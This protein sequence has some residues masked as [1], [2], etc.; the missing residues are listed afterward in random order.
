MR[1]TRLADGT[2]LVRLHPQDLIA[3]PWS[4]VGSWSN[5]FVTGE[6]VERRLPGGPA[7]RLHVFRDLEQEPV[8][9][10]LVGD[11]LNVALAASA[12]DEAAAA[13]GA[14]V[15]SGMGGRVRQRPSVL[16]P[17]VVSLAAIAGLWLLP[18]LSP[19]DDLPDIGYT[20]TRAQ[21][22]RMGLTDDAGQP[23]MEVRVLDGPDAGK[24]VIAT[25]QSTLPGTSA[26]PTIEPGDEVVVT[27][28]SGAA[29]GFN[30]VGD[31]WRMPV[32]LVLLAA[33][34]LFVTVVGGWR[35]V[36]SP[37]YGAVATSSE[38][39]APLQIGTPRTSI[40]SRPQATDTPAAVTTSRNAPR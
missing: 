18:D 14:A 23:A 22:T 17:L 29:G 9:A 28:Y 30:V 2:V 33:W 26:G 40:V 25:G 35:S 12:P 32:L 31:V 39:K 13:G 19:R 6:V 10:H 24:V 34:A 7:E 15:A 27:Q 20:S 8:P 1:A 4:V 37:G 21:V 36:A 38:L 16:L 3:A 11:Q 5:E